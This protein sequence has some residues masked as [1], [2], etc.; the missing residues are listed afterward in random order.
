M[1]RTSAILSAL[2]LCVSFPFA[3]T[4]QSLPSSPVIN[5]QTGRSLRFNELLPKGKVT[6]ICFWGTWCL[7]GKRQIK[8]IVR[9]L[10]HWHRL[11]DF[12]FIT[13]AED[14]QSVDG[15]E[16]KYARAQKWQF[17]HYLDA[18]NELKSKLKFHALPYTIIIDSKG[19]IIYSHTGYLEGENLQQELKRIAGK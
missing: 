10:P 5:L 16:Q 7:P 17:P 3:A 8:T 13:I 19:S 12:T 15:L 9:N 6:L 18:T 11:A 14:H 2:L 1:L 4:A